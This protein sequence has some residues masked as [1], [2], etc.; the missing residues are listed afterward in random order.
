MKGVHAFTA[1]YPQLSNVLKSKVAVFTHKGAITNDSTSSV[2]IINAPDPDLN[3]LWD[4]GDTCSVVTQAV[5]DKLELM[6]VRWGRVSTPNGEYDTPFF[7]V[8][9]GLPNHVMVGPLLVPLGNPSG[10][11]VLI[12]MDVIGR[13]DFAVSNYNGKTIFTFRVPS[14]EITDYVKKSE[15]ARWWESTEKERKR[16]SA[17]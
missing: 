7:Y 1:S 3:G 15:L 11:D 14:I 8:D 2:T 10:C 5:V 16:D 6:P 9:I 4:T 12:G 17:T 13:G